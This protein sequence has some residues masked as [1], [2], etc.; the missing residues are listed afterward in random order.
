MAARR[1]ALAAKRRQAGM[2]QQEL[3]DRLR[4]DRTTV[5]RWES[6]E[7]EPQP[8]LRPKLASL[9]SVTLAELDALLAD[10]PAAASERHDT[11]SAPGRPDFYGSSAREALAFAEALTREPTE[12]EAGALHERIALIACDYLTEPVE[13]VASALSSI[14]DETQSLLR[15]CR[16]PRV[17]GDLLVILA[18]ALALLA[19]AAMDVGQHRAAADHADAAARL[20]AEA[21]HSGVVAWS[22]GLQASNAYWSGNY[23]ASSRIASAALGS[24]EHGTTPVFLASLLARAAGRTGDQHTVRYAITA[25]ERARERAQSDEIGGVFAFSEAKQH[26]YAA[27]GHLGLGQDPREALHHAQQ[28]VALYAQAATPSFG[29]EAGARIDLATAYLRLAEPDGAFEALGPVLGLPAPLR[30]ASLRTRMLRLRREI[31]ACSGQ[32]HGGRELLE[33]VSD[34]ESDGRVA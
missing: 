30:V 23:A 4:I 12:P 14:R 26:L 24:A 5:T 21:G 32:A 9:L 2:S 19:N 27:S 8:W 31:A 18:R 6:G 33:A 15:T 1:A 29:D 20:A 3:A 10:A 13:P 34:F 7:N 22:R 25:A 16:S 11:R 28:A 17:A